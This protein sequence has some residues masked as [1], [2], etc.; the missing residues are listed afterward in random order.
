MVVA[1]MWDR[2]VKVGEGQAKGVAGRHARRLASVACHH[3]NGNP[4]CGVN[5]C[6]M[7][8]TTV[9][10]WQVVVAGVG[11]AR[12]GAVVGRQSLAMFSK[13]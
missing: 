12:C 6:K 2:H 4:T 8:S 7:G 9:H 11:A 10:V 1:D 13:P 3:T 5:V